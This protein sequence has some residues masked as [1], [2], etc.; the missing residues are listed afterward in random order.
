MKNEIDIRCFAS[1]HNRFSTS[2]QIEIAIHYTA[3]GLRRL[4]RAVRSAVINV[5]WLYNILHV[6]TNHE[7]VFVLVVGIHT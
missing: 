1:M 7:P 4:H 3:S 6:H 2:R 5:T